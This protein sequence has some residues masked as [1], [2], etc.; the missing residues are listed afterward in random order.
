VR[1]SIGR[2]SGLLG[3][4]VLR[5]GERVNRRLIAVHRGRSYLYVY[6]VNGRGPFT[7]Q[8]VTAGW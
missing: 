8:A 4:N 2:Q 1:W 3:F 7:V 6:R 5:R